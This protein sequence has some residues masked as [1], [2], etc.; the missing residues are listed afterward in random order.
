MGPV[1]NR[2]SEAN[3]N[4]RIQERPIKEK[5]QK[6][7]SQWLRFLTYTAL[8]GAIIVVGSSASADDIPPM[9]E[10]QIDAQAT[11][12]TVRLYRKGLFS[13][14]SHD[15]LLVAKGIAGRILYDVA[16]VTRSSLQLSVPVESI[17]VDPTDAREREGISGVFDEADRQ[18]IRETML[19]EEYLHSA[20]YPRIVVTTDRLEGELP[21]LNLVLNLRI[22]QTEGT[23]M[24]PAKVVIDGDTIRVTGEVTLVQSEHGVK[25]FSDW[26]GTLAVEDEILVRFQILARETQ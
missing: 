2:A 9:R 24:V 11:T 10:F 7:E 15:H 12:I 26:G 18:S 25:P 21:R 23:L 19:S 17:E 14:F 5:N 6:M 13:V 22:K 20:K 3:A 4:L 1:E 16:D 8:L